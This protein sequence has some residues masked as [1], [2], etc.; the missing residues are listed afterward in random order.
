[1]SIAKSIIYD[2]S[3]QRQL[4]SGD[5]LAAG[6][7]IPA[8]SATAA[9]TLTGALLSLGNYLANP[10]API[11]WTLDTAANIINAISGGLGIGTIQPGTTFRWR[12]IITTAQTGTVVATAN[13][14]IVVNRGALASNTAKEFL[15]T[16]NNGTPV[17]TLAS[18]T[19]NAS[20]IVTGFAPT[21]LA[22]L[23]VGMIVTNV[24]NGLQGATIIGINIAA[25][26]VTMSGNANATSATP[27]AI[28]FSPLITLDG[29]AP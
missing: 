6:E 21:D 1:M 19:T 23:S 8:T 18:M 24:V 5:L 11:T 3:I 7:V 4:Q 15:V 9:V 26:S 16:I 10:A 2:G 28:T 12:A 17:Q 20:A 13:T 29:L 14:G 25:G 27:V 22:K